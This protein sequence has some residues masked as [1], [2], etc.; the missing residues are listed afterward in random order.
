METLSNCGGSI[1][2][3]THPF[4][5]CIDHTVSRE[6]KINLPQIIR[7]NIQTDNL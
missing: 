3:E 4:L 5:V 1:S 6:T 7:F 2:S